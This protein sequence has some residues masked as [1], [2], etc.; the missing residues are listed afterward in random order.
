MRKAFSTLLA[1]AAVL[2]MFWYHVAPNAG[3]G[4]KDGTPVAVPYVQHGTRPDTGEAFTVE[5]T[6]TPDVRLC[7][8]VKNFP[9]A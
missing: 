2:P 1:G 7:T 3:V 5:G 8:M 4:C 9:K 6:Y